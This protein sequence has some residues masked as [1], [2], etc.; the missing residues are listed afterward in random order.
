MDQI[1]TY[2]IDENIISLLTGEND[3][4]KVKAVKSGIDS[5]VLEKI[6]ESVTQYLLEKGLTADQA[7]FV[8]DTEWEKLPADW[9]KYLKEPEL[10]NKISSTAQEVY[11]KY[12]TENFP[13][14]SPEDQETV[15]FYV[16]QAVAMTQAI[17]EQAPEI[18]KTR[19][20]LLQKYN[21]TTY[22]ELAE[23]IKA[24][25]ASNPPIST[26]VQPENRVEQAQS[27]PV[28]VPVNTDVNTDSGDINTTTSTENISDHILQGLQTANQNGASPLLKKILDERITELSQNE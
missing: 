2:F 12:F 15:I 6:Q 18:E 11:K 16:N 23:K 10:L 19:Q 20:E 26:E 21:V 24:E 14:I 28:E 13:K 7:K 9:Q 1:T 22:E 25:K 4:E 5:E 3:G 27:Q 17:S 8:S